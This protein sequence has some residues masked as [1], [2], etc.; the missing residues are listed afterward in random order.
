MSPGV[1]TM[2]GSIK[3]GPG[4]QSC[5]VQC[6]GDGR[7]LVVPVRHSNPAAVAAPGMK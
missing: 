5:G 4:D 1:R 2:R 7:G 3:D 6:A